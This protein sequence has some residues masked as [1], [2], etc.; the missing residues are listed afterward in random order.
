MFTGIVEE[1][2][3][4]R[5]I[6]P[7]GDG[8]RIVIDASTVLGDVELGASIAVNG[9]C[10]TVVAHDDH[11]WTAQAVPETLARTNLGELQP[12][13]VVN[14]ER[15]LAADGRFGG[16][17]VQGHVDATTAIEAITDH[18]DGSRRLR[19]AWPVG[20]DH[21]VVE[22]GSIALDGVSLTVAAVDGDG[23]E[24]ALIPHTL[25][26]TTFGHRRVGSTVNVETDVLAKHV[27]RLLTASRPQETS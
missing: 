9:C 7:Q 15:P 19:F 11:T 5:S 12:G 18:P 20:L 1:L 25:A 14:L 27:E 23:F 17:I 2:G 22:K 4:V 16:H 13:D 24:I 8:A 10:L 21:Y 6:E 3:T 26:E